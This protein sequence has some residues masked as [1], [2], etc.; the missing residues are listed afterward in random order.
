MLQTGSPFAYRSPVIPRLARHFKLLREFTIPT[1]LKM[2]Q[3]AS[4]GGSHIGGMIVAE[5]AGNCLLPGTFRYVAVLE[6]SCVS[7]Q[8]MR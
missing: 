7:P 5:S 6:I 2:G 1:S 4:V 3:S 8:E